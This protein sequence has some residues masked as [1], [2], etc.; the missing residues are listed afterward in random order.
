MRPSQAILLCC[1]CLLASQDQ[2][3]SVNRISRQQNRSAEIDRLILVVK[4]SRPVRP[5]WEH[6]LNHGK[7]RPQID[8]FESPKKYLREW[9]MMRHIHRVDPTRE[10]I[11][12]P[13]KIVPLHP[14]S[15]LD[16]QRISSHSKKI[17]LLDPYDYGRSY[18]L[19]PIVLLSNIILVTIGN[20]HL[21]MLLNDQQARIKY[22][23]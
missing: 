11:F 5:W 9:V 23:R 4:S 19:T 18:L 14:N 10:D 21:S 1:C 3:N 17:A 12:Y 20:I 8:E 7:L 2:Q 16:L 15:F 6:G 22:L 13:C